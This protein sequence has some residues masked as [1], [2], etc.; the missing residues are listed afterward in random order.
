[1]LSHGACISSIHEDVE[2][3]DVPG[4]P[5]YRATSGGHVLSKKTG[6]PLRPRPHWRTGHLRV[7]LY[8][9]H[10]PEVVV[11]D[12]STHRCRRFVDTYVHV[13]ICTAF[14]GLPPFEGALVLHWDDDPAH[15]TPENLRWGSREDNARDLARNLARNLDDDGF[16]W[17]SGTWH[18][19]ESDEPVA[20]V[21][22]LMLIADEARLMREPA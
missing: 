17:A 11:R 7:R 18:G 12:G 9:R 8:G 21:E 13:L 16:D 3:R 14:H 22:E 4:F 19:P 6:E 5:G 10:L 1:M 15:N 2:V 20:F